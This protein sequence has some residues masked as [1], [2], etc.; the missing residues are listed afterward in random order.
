MKT[1]FLKVA[2]VAAIA[3]VSGLNVF[4]AQKSV[5]LSDVAVAN[6]NASA[7]G[8]SG[9]HI[10]CYSGNGSAFLCKCG[11]CSWGY[12]GTSTKGTCY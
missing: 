1:N 6:L 10:T 5:A 4:N 7:E 11:S 2:F 8:E 9:Y 3:L 12:T